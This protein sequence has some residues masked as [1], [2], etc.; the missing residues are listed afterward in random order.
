M[1]SA[2]AEAVETASGNIMLFWSLYSQ[3]SIRMDKSTMSEASELIYCA[4]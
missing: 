2:A 3:Q 4:K 1:P